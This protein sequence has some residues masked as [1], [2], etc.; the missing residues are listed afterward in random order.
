MPKYIR[1]TKAAE[2]TGYKADYLKDLYHFPGQNFAIKMNPL[3]NNSPIMYDVDAFLK[4][5]KQ[6]NRRAM[7]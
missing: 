2:L 4:W 6:T 3:K 5:V 7:K 1:V